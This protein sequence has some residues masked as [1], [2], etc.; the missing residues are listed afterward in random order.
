MTK[1]PD[2]V[3]KSELKEDFILARGYWS[4]LWDG[5]L[6]LDPGYFEAYLRFSEVPWRRGTL[7]A[8]VKEMVYIAVDAVTTHLFEPGIRIHVR[9]ALGHGASLLEI[10]EVIEL[11]T[12]I[13]LE[14]SSF[15]LPILLEEMAAAGLAEDRHTAPLDADSSALKEEYTRILGYWPAG[16]EAGLRLDVDYFRTVL[17]LTKAPFELNA[18][19][20]R[21]AQLIMIAANASVTHANPEAARA[22]I[23]SALAL[24]VTPGQI[25]E[26][27]QMASVLG[28]HSATISIPI[29]I[30]EANRQ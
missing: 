21:T 20:P 2:R 8:K 3:R 23:R 12:L 27:L 5:L 28:V 25:I 14:A 22:H 29:A 7:D 18:L 4:P 30:D 10:V 13:G 16:W 26:V 1:D 24:G 15:G 9:N 6:D 17:R 11:C 19:D